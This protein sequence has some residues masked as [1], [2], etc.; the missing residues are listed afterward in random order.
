MY[1]KLYKMDKVGEKS[2]SI[3]FYVPHFWGNNHV[4][5]YILY[6]DVLDK[7]H[8][9]INFNPAFLKHLR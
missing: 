1:L 2:T 4:K 8:K 3:S 6:A 7:C 9:N 5:H